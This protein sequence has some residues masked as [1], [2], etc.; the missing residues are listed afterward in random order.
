[1]AYNPLIPQPT[2]IIS[3]SQPQILENF[4][5]LNTQ[6][7]IDHVAWNVGGA[8]AGHHKAVHLLNVA[9]PVTG[10]TEGGAYTKVKGTQSELFY[11]YQSS[12]PIQQ[13]T[14]QSSPFG[15]PFAL[16]RVVGSFGGTAAING[17]PINVASITTT[18]PGVLTITFTT[19]AASSDYTVFYTVTGPGTNDTGGGYVK[20]TTGVTVFLNTSL[21]GAGT[22]VSVAIILDPAP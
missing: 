12:G 14:N 18:A 19:A 1:M 21:T 7:G 9:D 16:V 8:T 3:Q 22:E 11:R 5:Q 6:F 4:T 2:D 20:L 15:G 17:T 13:L 10:G